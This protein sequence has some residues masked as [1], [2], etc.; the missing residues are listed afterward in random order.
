M[1]QRRPRTIAIVVLSLAVLVAAYFGIRALTDKGDGALTAS[2]TIEAVEV[3]VSPEIGGK[4]VEVSVEEGAS[5]QA[6]DELFRLDDTLLQAQRNV[7]SAALDLANAAAKTAEAALASARSQYD[8]AVDAARQESVAARTASWRAPNPADYTLPG[9]YFSQDEAIQAAQAEA[10]AAQTDLDAV[11]SE[12]D[13]LEKAPANADFLAAEGRLSRARAAFVTANAVLARAEAANDNAELRSAAQ[14]RYDSAQT[15]LSDAQSAYDGLKD[16]D[17]AKDI[18]AA[19]ARLASAQERYEAAQDNL[20]ALQTGMDSPRVAAAQAAVNQAQA[21][22]DQAHL[23]IMQAQA[24]LGL[25][26]AQI[27]KLT[28]KAPADG[29]IL[30]RSIQPGEVVAAGAAAVSLGRLDNLT[31]TVYVPEE[32]YGELSLGQAADVT[33]DSFPDEVFSARI[34]HIAD[35]AEFTPRN[36]QTTE[37]RKA[38]VFAVKLQVEDPNG[39]LKPGMPADI[40]FTR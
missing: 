39:K 13:T 29:V 16:S 31:I 15:E 27:A 17:A 5:V 34:I 40:T 14:D 11:R 22:A 23:S 21:A 25:L 1:K 4:V 30:T 18:L 6:G 20:L 12:L 2:G 28:V 19:R 9:W 3:T 32:R 38:T 26:D 36:V 35:Q 33:V 10:T 8:L 37:G 7:A 24:N